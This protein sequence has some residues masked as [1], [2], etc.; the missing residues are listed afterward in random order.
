MRVLFLGTD[1]FL[2]TPGS[3]AY[4]R[5]QDMAAAYPTDTFDCIVFSHRGHGVREAVAI[6][7]NAHAYPTNSRSRFLYGWDALRIARRISRPDVVTAQ[8][9]FE[10]GL[11]GLTIARRAHAPLLVQVHTDFLS[12]VFARHSFL[13]RIRLIIA[14]YVLPRVRGGYAVSEKI[15]RAIG[16][17]YV[18][19]KP[20]DVLPIFVDT[21]A[22]ARSPRAPHDR[23]TMLWA[24][25]L[26]PEK[27]PEE[28][29]RALAAARAHGTDAELIFAGSGSLESTLKE[30]A[31]RLDLVDAVTFAGWQHDLAPYYARTDLLL[32]TSTYE[33]Y[34]LVIVEALAAHVPVL[35]TDVGIAREAGAVIAQGDYADAL[36][37]W[38]AGPRASGALANYPYA[39][40]SDYL[41]KL[42]A[43]YAAALSV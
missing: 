32:V 11:A 31:K 14:A 5:V 3:A 29:L 4:G 27:R 23:F 21:S 39:D 7:P 9:P 18:L 36:V 15:A 16:R 22:L 2:F 40:K 8:D 35:S 6:A 25:R 26:E 42:H 12:P 33:G 1:R 19:R 17:H 10:T 43:H 38:L 20:F 41:A 24:G 28:A 30:E 13:N 34:G 37:A